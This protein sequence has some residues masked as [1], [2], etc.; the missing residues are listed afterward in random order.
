VP[1]GAT[2]GGGPR[3]DDAEEPAIFGDGG[4]IDDLDGAEAG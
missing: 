1:A 3:S 2:T 4:D